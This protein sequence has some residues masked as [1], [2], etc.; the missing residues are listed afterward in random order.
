MLQLFRTGSYSHLNQYQEFRKFVPCK[1]PEYVNYTVG[2]ERLFGLRPP[3][4]FLKN[5]FS[6]LMSVLDSLSKANKESA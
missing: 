6:L 3:D 2:I 5:Y 1:Y 4:V